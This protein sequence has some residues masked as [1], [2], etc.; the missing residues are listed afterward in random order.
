[1]STNLL[2]TRVTSELHAAFLKPHGFRKVGATFSRDRA[3]YVEL[4]NIQ[5]SPWNFR[6]RPWEF[7]LNVG[8]RFP[9]IALVG[10]AKVTPTSEHAGGRSNSIVAGSPPSFEVI[11]ST[12]EVVTPVLWGIIDAAS[13]ALPGLL[14]PVLLRAQSGLWSPLPLPSTWATNAAT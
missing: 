3:N 4:Y 1:M 11:E 8:V 2:G 6:D 12:V 5:G 14:G 10:N 13:A 9:G 7:Y